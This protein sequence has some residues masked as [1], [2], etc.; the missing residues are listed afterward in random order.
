LRVVRV[1]V[2][3]A[4]VDFAF[5]ISCVISFRDASRVCAHDDA[6]RASCVCALHDTII[7]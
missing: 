1:R 2:V 7:S 4:F 3:R 5:V 6:T